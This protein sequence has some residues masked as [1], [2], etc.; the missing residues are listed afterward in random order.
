MTAK[1]FISHWTDDSNKF[2][3]QIQFAGF[4]YFAA[5]SLAQGLY[6]ALF[7]SIAV[8]PYSDFFMILSFILA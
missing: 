7:F 8:E 4:P 6:M 3:L 1:A 2:L 5:T